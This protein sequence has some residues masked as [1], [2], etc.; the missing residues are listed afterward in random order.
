MK[1][2]KNVTFKVINFIYSLQEKGLIENTK[3]N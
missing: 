3:R 1:R 2:M